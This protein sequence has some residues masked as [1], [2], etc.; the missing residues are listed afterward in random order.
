[1]VAYYHLLMIHPFIYLIVT[2][3]TYLQSLILKLINYMNG[4]VQ[5]DYHL[6]RQKPNILSLGLRNSHVIAM[7]F[8]SLLME[9]VLTK[10]AVNMKKKALNF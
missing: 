5:T 9:L 8:P 2:Y 7:T 3:K 1:M 6:T 4:S 10:L